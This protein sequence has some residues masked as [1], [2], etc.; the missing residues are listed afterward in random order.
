MF[1]YVY[2]EFVIIFII[3]SNIYKIFLDFVSLP[4][5]RFN[6]VSEV[7]PSYNINDDKNRRIV[8][9][10][11]ASNLRKNCIPPSKL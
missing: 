3:I 1:A 7:F 5:L 6:N 10:S 8:E 2:F 4:F 9:E 11:T